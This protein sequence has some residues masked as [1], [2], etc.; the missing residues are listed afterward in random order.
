MRLNINNA[1]LNKFLD[2]ARTKY[3]VGNTPQF[4]TF[5][6]VRNS[7]AAFLRLDWQINPKHLLTL[8]NN[9][10]FDNNKNGLGDNTA[11]NFF[12]SYGN[13]KNL[14]N[15]LL[16][17]LRSNLKPNVTNE[18]KA[19][20]LYTYQDSFQNDELGHAVPRAIVEN[21][22]TPIDGVNK[23]TNIQIGGHRFAQESFKN[24]VFQIVDN[25]YYNTDKI[26]YTFGADLMYTRAK[27]I[28]GSEV[29]GRFHFREASTNPD[30]LYNFN[31]LIAYRFYRE[32][33]LMEDPSVK[34]NIWNVGVYGQMQTK[35]AKGLDLMAGIR[36]DYGGYPK[37]EFNQKLFDEMGIRTDNQIK[38][39]IIQPRFQFDWNINEGIK[40]S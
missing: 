6:K 5:D 11:I 22:L 39:F 30:N 24:N 17:T 4:G 9:F 37:A 14:D 23:A 20:Y 27:S 7:D 2:I 31:N 25:L 26:K 1:T 16:L 13:D 32:V 38:S 12:E 36:L 40:I 18:L 21:I 35:I 29:N 10:T 33:P 15:S 28:Y 34:S 8:R 19:Q 3:G